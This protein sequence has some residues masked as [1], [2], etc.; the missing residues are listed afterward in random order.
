VPGQ[1]TITFNAQNLASGIYFYQLHA[2]S[3]TE[4]KKLMLLK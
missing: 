1:Y 2:G 4:T 3:F